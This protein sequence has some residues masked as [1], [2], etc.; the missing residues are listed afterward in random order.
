MIRGDIVEIA[1]HRWDKW[2]NVIREGR[3]VLHVNEDLDT[4]RGF[5]RKQLEILE[6]PACAIL[7]LYFLC[8]VFSNYQKGQ[9][10][11]FDRIKVPDWLPLPFGLEWEKGNLLRGK[12]VYP[13]TVWS[14]EDVK[15][16]R[17]SYGA[18]SHLSPYDPET[19]IVLP[20]SHSV[21]RFVPRGRPAKKT[22]DGMTW[23]QMKP[24]L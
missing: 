24:N 22:R 4:L 3:Q 11:Y 1:L 6:L 14:E 12:R 5:A 16:F 8:C 10:F 20:I 18:G 9:R 19:C 17:R 15:F 21:R 23:L 2:Q 7:E 13:P